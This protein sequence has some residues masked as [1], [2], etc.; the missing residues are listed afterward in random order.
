LQSA[1]VELTL[2]AVIKNALILLRINPSSLNLLSTENSNI[3][4]LIN[5]K[6]PPELPFLASQNETQ[7][8][9]R[10]T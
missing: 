5:D 2:A 8:A 9:N 1:W 6:F 10:E 7:L 3:P 4:N